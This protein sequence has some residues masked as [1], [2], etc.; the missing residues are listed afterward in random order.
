MF[1]V[2]EFRRPFVWRPYVMRWHRRGFLAC[3][4]FVAVD[5][6]FERWDSFLYAHFGSEEEWVEE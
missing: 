4:G 6:H 5:V 3:W 2:I 1:V